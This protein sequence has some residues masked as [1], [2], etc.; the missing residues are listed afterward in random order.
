MDAQEFPGGI[1]EAEQV[2]AFCQAAFRM[3]LS[4]VGFLTLAPNS[5]VFWYSHLLE[6]FPQFIV[7]HTDK[8]FGIVN[9]AEI[10][11]ILE[12]SCFFDDP[13]DV[14]SLISGSSAFSKTSLNIWNFMVLLFM[15]FSWRIVW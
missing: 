10:D 5:Q 15:K 9:K 3:T 12:F 11:V 1:P 2:L 8:G 13:L 4:R 6:N 14:C 7:I